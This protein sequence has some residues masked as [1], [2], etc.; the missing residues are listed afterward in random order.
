MPSQG[1]KGPGM[2]RMFRQA[3]RSFALH[4]G[5]LRDLPAFGPQGSDRDVFPTNER[6]IFYPPGGTGLPGGSYAP[7]NPSTV[8]DWRF[9]NLNNFNSFGINVSATIPV[10]PVNYHRCYILIQ[11]LDTVVTL[12]ITFGVQPNAN[13]SVHIIPATALTTSIFEWGS[14][15]PYSAMY[16]AASGVPTINPI[17]IEGTQVSPTTIPVGV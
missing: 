5:P 17:G 11:N 4:G 15:V 14:V 10:L 12:F 3:P 13:N 7:A 6:R 8:P 2:P 9:P 16:I 1:G